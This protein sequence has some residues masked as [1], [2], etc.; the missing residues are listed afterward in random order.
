MIIAYKATPATIAPTITSTNTAAFAVGNSGNVHG[1]RDGNAGS[2]AERNGS[3]ANW[4]NVHAGDRSPGRNA[5]GR[6]G[7]HLL[8]HDYGA[9]RNH[10][11]RNAELHADGEPAPGNHQREQHKLHGRDSGNVHGDGDGFPIATLAE[12]ATLPS[13][14]TFTD[15]KNNTGTLAWT[16]AVA[17]GSYATDVHGQ[18]RRAA[19]RDAE[20][21]AGSK[22]R[23]GNQQRE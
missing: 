4:S 14:V 8:N 1:D 16:A 13:G 3:A 15:N 18:Q 6:Y 7:R 5:G 11:E 19:K 9:E 22:H 12:T 20:F 10:T 21:Y 2:D 23:P 17:S